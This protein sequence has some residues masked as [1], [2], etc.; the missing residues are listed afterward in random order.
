MVLLGY[1]PGVE[2]KTDPKE[3]I[4]GSNVNRA[5]GQAR[6]GPETLRTVAHA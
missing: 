2:R 1:H 3:D 5:M 4:S 6:K